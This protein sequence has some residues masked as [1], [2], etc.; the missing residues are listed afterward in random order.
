VIVFGP[1][2]SRRLGRSLGV[3]NI[4]PKHCSYSCVYCQVGTTVGREA[5]RRV[6]FDPDEVA[7]TVEDKVAACR[8]AGERIDYVTFVPDGEPTLDLH[9]GR[10]IRALAP[11]GLPVAVISNGSLLSLGAVRDELAAADLV[12]VKVDAVEDGL[13]RRIDRPH[14]RLDLETVLEGIADF[15]A[16][17]GGDLLTETM[18]VAGVNDSAAAVEAVA[19]FVAAL[20][21]RRAYLAA[22][23]RPPAEPDVRPPRSEEL[24]RAHEIFARRLDSVELLTS[25]EEGEFGSTGDPVEDLLAILAVHPMR[26]DAA[27]RYLSRAGAPPGALAELVGGGRVRHL[28]DQGHTYVLQRPAWE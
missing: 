26:E 19:D 5:A 25:P 11:L 2:P 23:T 6:F 3:N 16:G 12:S 18:L 20:A 10:E 21:P 28:D 14:P 27:A 22:P 15:A 13:W 7:R 9:L 4:P 17:Y 1:V 8:A 24:V